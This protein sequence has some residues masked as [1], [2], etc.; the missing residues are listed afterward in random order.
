[1]TKPRICTACDNPAPNG[2]TICGRC[3]R[4]TR[5]R[6]GDMEAHRQELELTMTRQAK[7]QAERHGGRSSTTPLVFAE[8]A[9]ELL[10]EQR[11]IL[12]GWC[13]LINEEIDATWPRRDT[14]RAMAMQ[15]EA[16]MPELRKHAACGDLV[17]EMYE[18][19]RHA[20]ACIDYPDDRH[21]VK[22]GDCV[23]IDE[24]GAP[25]R[26]KIILHYPHE[27]ETYADC[28]TCETRWNGTQLNRLGQ[29]ISKR[30]AA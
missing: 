20:V 17:G 7:L 9:A 22:V 14:I 21:R 16:H 19:T 6:L 15:I 29:R 28:R 8:D 10:W 18:F 24:D 23:I 5:R 26:G 27:G 1:M 4:D 13:K 25:C 11:N 30:A 3:E 2:V 12:I